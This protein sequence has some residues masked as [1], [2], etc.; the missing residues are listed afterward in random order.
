[1]GRRPAGG[2]SLDPR[3]GGGSPGK[4]GFSVVFVAVDPPFFL[5]APCFV[6][7]CMEGV[8]FPGHYHSPE[9][10]FPHPR[11]FLNVQKLNFSSSIHN[12]I[13]L[14]QEIDRLIP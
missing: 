1:M 5:G 2:G 14:D 7:Y 8:F 10:F 11:L 13:D 4:E 3:E 9:D 6:S 12:V